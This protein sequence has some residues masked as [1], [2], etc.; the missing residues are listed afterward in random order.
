MIEKQN[1]KTLR[2][3]MES[4]A[5]LG[6]GREMLVRW[7]LQTGFSLSEL[8]EAADVVAKRG[9]FDSVWGSALALA[10][11]GRW[12][13]PWGNCLMWMSFPQLGLFE[14]V[15]DERLCEGLISD[16][17]GK[18]TPSLVA[19]CTP[20]LS[21]ARQSATKTFGRGESVHA[22][23]L[24]DKI[25]EMLGCPLSRMEP[26]QVTR[27]AQGGFYA[28]HNDWFAPS[29]QKWGSQRQR[30]ATVVVYLSSP[31]SGGQTIIEPLGMRFAPRQGHAL[32]F[33]YD[34]DVSKEMTLHASAP[35]EG[36]PKWIGTQWL[37][38]G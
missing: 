11:S 21:D 8:N 23:Q 32:Y 6:I 2:E 4:Q 16:A 3:W 31:K 5:R 20:R 33:A 15:A 24:Q 26:L 37:V 35:A 18:I 22:D 9:A 30:A 25:V 29:H 1:P 38:E 13:Q 14:G 10:E 28:P 7:G 34:D 36:A 12:V 19:S 17:V 27:Y